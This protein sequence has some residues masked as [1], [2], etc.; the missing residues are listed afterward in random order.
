MD[1][2]TGQGCQRVIPLEYLEGLNEEDLE[3]MRD[4][5]ELVVNRQQNRGVGLEPSD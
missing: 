5:L 4:F 3:R 2:E 1:N